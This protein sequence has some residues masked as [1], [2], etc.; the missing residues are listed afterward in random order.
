M[1]ELIVLALSNLCAFLLGAW[2][3]HRAK[4]DLSP[5]PSIPRRIKVESD[6]DPEP[7]YA[8]GR[9]IL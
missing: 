5:I 4:H 7:V 8:K 2:V 1:A 9:V 3:I 6:P